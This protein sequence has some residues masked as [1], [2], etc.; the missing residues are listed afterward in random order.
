MCDDS[1]ISYGN[2]TRQEKTRKDETRQ[3]KTRQENCR[4]KLDNST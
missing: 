3:D 1:R 4:H 2:E